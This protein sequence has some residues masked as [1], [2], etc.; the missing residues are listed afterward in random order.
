MTQSCKVRRREIHSLTLHHSLKLTFYSS[1]SL[2]L[3]NVAIQKLSTED[4][5]LIDFNR[6]DRIAVLE[7]TIQLAEDKK[8]QCLSKRWKIRRSHGRHLIL[9]DVFEKIAGWAQ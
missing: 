2:D 5:T 8:R 1:K 6:P 7:D 4:Q 9:R 3:W